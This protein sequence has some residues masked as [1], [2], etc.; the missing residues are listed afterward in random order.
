MRTRESSLCALHFQ[1]DNDSTT[2][3]NDSDEQANICRMVDDDISESQQIVSLYTDQTGTNISRSVSIIGE[4]IDLLYSHGTHLM[5]ISVQ[6][7]IATVV[8]AKPFPVDHHNGIYLILTVEDIT[9]ED[10]CC[11]VYSF[12]YFTFPSKVD[13]TLPYAWVGNSDNHGVQEQQGLGS[14]VSIRPTNEDIQQ[15][16]AC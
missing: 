4:Y 14:E 2:S 16:V 11:A 15:F 7:V 5:C 1:E 9:M 8:R 6:E 13:Y 12:H 10:L 3:S